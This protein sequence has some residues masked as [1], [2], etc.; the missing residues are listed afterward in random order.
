MSRLSRLVAASP[1]LLTAVFIAKLQLTGTLGYYVNSRTIWIVLLGGALFI[2][3]GAV[4]VWRAWRGDREYRPGWRTGA[5]VIPVLVGLVVPAHPLSALSGQ[6]SS[7]GSLQLAS[8]VSSGA[9]GD[10]FGSWISDL[11]NH[12]GASWWSGQP[13]TVVGF[14][15]HQY[16]MSQN[17]FI[18]GR[19]LVTC[20]VVDAQLM[21]FPVHLV[22]GVVPVEGAWVQVRGKFG[23]HFWT[24][25]TG[26]NYPIIEHARIQSVS[27]PSSPYLSP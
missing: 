12:P 26:S 6:A 14:A 20:C 13:V 24:D 2:A 17:S 22:K 18:V 11:A 4:S 8:H 9:P 1:A 7:L 27:I 16:G 21:G 3:I 15:S 25:Q 19:Y 5:F 23:P 10:A